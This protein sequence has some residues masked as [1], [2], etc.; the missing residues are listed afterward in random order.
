MNIDRETILKALADHRQELVALGVVSIGVF[1]SVAR[2]EA[3]PL[4]DVDL[5]VRLR[6]NTFDSYMDVKEFVER[7]FNRRVDLVLESSIK[8]LLRPRIEK[9]AVHA[10]GF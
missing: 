3:T 4:S 10:A 6:Q 9:E 7:L 8:P 1:G 2:N 5:V